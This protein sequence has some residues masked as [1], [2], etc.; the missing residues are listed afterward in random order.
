MPGIV[1]LLP[2]ATEWVYALGLQDQLRAVTFECDEPAS[3]RTQHQVVVQGL[4]TA[5]LAPA[6]IDALVK[7]RV[8]AGQP[9]YSLD[10][11][12]MAAI[13][14]EVVLTQDLCHVC[15]LPAGE[16]EAALRVS[17]CPGV[18]VT[19]D[20]HT[21][22]QVLDCALQVA[23]ACGCE[24]AGVRVRAGL[25]ARLDRVRAAVG[26]RE[27]PRVLVLEW[28]EPA[29]LAGHWVPDIV[30]AAGGEAVLARPGARSVQVGWD[31]ISSCAADVVLVAPCGYGLEDAV[32]QARDVRGRLPG[33]DVWAI[34]AGGLVT[35]PGP[36][37]VEGVEALAW[38][39][40]PTAVPQPPAGRVA[41]MPPGGPS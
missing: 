29:Y 20:P 13:T 14:P 38:A 28:I 9:L 36:R 8:A 4:D 32:R 11:Q 31:E 18:V 35:R 33:A 19:L 37:L 2:S 39:L 30:R 40:H 1:S 22:D 7:A 6:A 26:G 41:R 3:A 10:E 25:R 23:S 12:A 5:A 21:L 16:V 15:A 24:S 17:G 34:D 27:R